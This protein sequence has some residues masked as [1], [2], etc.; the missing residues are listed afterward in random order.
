MS[1]S[2]PFVSGIV[3]AAGQS[4][5]FPGPPPK[6]LL[7]F[8]GEPLV[9]RICRRVLASR[10]REVILVVGHEAEAVRRAAQDLDLRVV[11]NPRFRTGQSSSVKV[12][13]RAVSPQAS[14]ALFI[15][16]DQPF[17]GVPLLNRLIR[18]YEATGGPIVAPIF[19]G[20]RGAPVLFDRSL[21]AELLAVTGDEGGR[22]VLGRHPDELVT[23]AVKSNRPL[24]D[25]DTPED[26]L[27]LVR[28]NRS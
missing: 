11:E 10:C 24:L 26:Y 20:R 22:Q 16:V 12:G 7:P 17:V 3:L 2:G 13:L 14:A 19:E 8:G 1:S 25:I 15:P 21:F 28:G 5:R 23:V 4:T 27:V 6:Q 18:A 9:H